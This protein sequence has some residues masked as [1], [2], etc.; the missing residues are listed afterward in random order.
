MKRAAST[1]V[2]CLCAL[3][4]G[5]PA[6][7]HDIGPTTARSVDGRVLPVRAVPPIPLDPRPGHV[8]LTF[9]DGPHPEWTPRVLDVLAEHD[10][11]ATF[12][13]VGWRV[14]QH[15]EIVRRMID[16]GHSV[17]N[18]TWSHPWLTHHSDA[19]VVDQL[20]R[21]SEIIE[22]V[23]GRTPHCVRPPFG[24][25][26]TRVRGIFADLGLHQMMWERD[27]QEWRGSAGYLVRFLVKHT[28]SGEVVLIHDT[29]GPV[30]ITALPGIIAGLRDKGLEFDTICDPLLRWDP[31]LPTRAGS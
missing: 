4:G 24:A 2:V 7:A 8:A 30:V 21:T 31:P 10:V 23:T 6:A 26:S 19:T 1:L 16:E 9:D 20:V 17:Q 12:F 5:L 18:H 27:P 11:K 25:T 15:P 13:V 22:T 28:R 3:L 14:E 29:S